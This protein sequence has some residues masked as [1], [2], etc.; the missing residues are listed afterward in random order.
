MTE[1][2]FEDRNKAYGAYK[3]RKLSVKNSNIGFLIAVS[4]FLLIIFSPIILNFL[5]RDSSDPYAL[6]PTYEIVSEVILPNIASAQIKSNTHAIEPKISVEKPKSQTPKVVD[7][8][9]EIIEPQQEKKI[10][11]PTSNENQEQT[12]AK[13]QGNETGNSGSGPASDLDAPFHFVDIM[14][15]FPGGQRA[16]S[17][18][19]ASNLKYPNQ[20]LQSR[21]EGTVFIGFVVDKNGNIMNIKILKGLHT[22]CD[23]EAIRVMRSMPQWIPGKHHG[24]NVSVNYRIPIVFKMSR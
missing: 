15:Q 8:K 19:L 3:L 12:A 24:T 4:I 7:E 21:V 23:E 10:E 16:L 1:I 14:P 22:A 5:N 11:P 17:S 18:F 20:A 13:D 6:D 9:V 2:S